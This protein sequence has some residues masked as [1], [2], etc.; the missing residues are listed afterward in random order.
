MFLGVCLLLAQ[1]Q[2]TDAHVTEFEADVAEMRQVITRAHAHT[3][4]DTHRPTHPHTHTYTRARAHTDRHTHTHTFTHTFTQIPLS[5]TLS[6]LNSKYEV[7]TVSRIDQ[8][9]ALF[10]RI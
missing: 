9:I 10:C 1:G 8:I 4:T 3:H 2:L 5:N 7:A 6:S